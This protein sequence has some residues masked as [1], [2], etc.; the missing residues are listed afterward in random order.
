L[1]QETRL[2]A[3]L[4]EFHELI[5]GNHPSFSCSDLVKDCFHFFFGNFVLHMDV[6]EHA[7][8]VFQ[9]NL[10]RSIVLCSPKNFLLE[11]RGQSLGVA[12]RG[13]IENGLVSKKSIGKQFGTVHTTTE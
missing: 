10:T 7:L 5:R 3:C 8:H 6:C 12:E 13:K 4:D 1:Q 9:S 11:T 2:P